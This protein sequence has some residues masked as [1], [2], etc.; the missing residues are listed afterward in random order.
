[1]YLIDLQIYFVTHVQ[2]Y[3]YS[4]TARQP[5]CKY[6][7]TFHIWAR[8][9]TFLT[10]TTRQWLI[11]LDMFPLIREVDDKPLSYI[12]AFDALAHS[13]VLKVWF[14]LAFSKVR[15]I[16]AESYYP[17][18]HYSILEISKNFNR[19][20]ARNLQKRNIV[21]RRPVRLTLVPSFVF[22]L[23]KNFRRKFSSQVM[24]IHEKRV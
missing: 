7:S 3:A 2:S 18:A 22:S 21:L 5:H 9:K 15:N 19:K 16:Y 14:S 6:A 24:S 23:S 1:M 17:T 12:R 13:C 20:Y 8:Y 10:L 11:G 4:Q